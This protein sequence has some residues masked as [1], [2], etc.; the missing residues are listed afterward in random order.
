MS[1]HMHI[2]IQRVCDPPLFRDQIPEGR[3]VLPILWDKV[4]ILEKGTEDGRTSLM[5]VMQDEEGN[6]YVT[7]CTARIFRSIAAA[8]NG[9]ME[10]F[11]DPG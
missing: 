8:L 1:Q 6:I 2:E 10:R 5:L 3:E 11:G 7:Q 4:G 9:A